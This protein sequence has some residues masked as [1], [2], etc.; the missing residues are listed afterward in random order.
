MVSATTSMSQ[1]E[2]PQTTKT[3]NIPLNKR[4]KAERMRS[5]ARDTILDMDPTLTKVYGDYHHPDEESIQTS[6]LKWIHRFKVVTDSDL[7]KKIAASRFGIFIGKCHPGGLKDIVTTV[8]HY[9]TWLFIYDDM[10]EKKTEEIESL[11]ERT[12]SVLKGSGVTKTDSGLMKGLHEVV[13]RIDLLNP[14]KAWK[15]RFFNEN[16]SYCINSLKEGF[17]RTRNRIPTLAEYLVE[18][19][20]F[21]GTKIMFALIELVLGITIPEATFNS[22]L[23]QKILLLAANAVNWEN[24]M[25]SAEKE[26]REGDVHNLIFVL[27]Q[28]FGYTI[29]EAFA[30]AR[31]M[32]DRNLEE[33]HSLVQEAVSIGGDVQKYVEGIMG[34]LA[35]HHYWAKASPR[36]SYYFT[37]PRLMRRGEVSG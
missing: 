20:E 36:Y 21:S 33:L 4:L 5:V 18:R 23:I 34:W 29:E 17:N 9:A 15:D 30:H 7:L 11:H 27:Q 32:F 26:C 22:P 19:P 3:Q 13:E 6:T 31:R 14:S 2:S 28:E 37:S 24:D 10:I 16:R 8:A 12:L 35:G 25:L 1:R